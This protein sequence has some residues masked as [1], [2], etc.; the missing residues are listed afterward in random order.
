MQLIVNDVQ[1]GGLG[2]MMTLPPDMYSASDSANRFYTKQIRARSS[3][4]RSM[5]SM[6]FKTGCIGREPALQLMSQA[7]A[8]LATNTFPTQRLLPATTPRP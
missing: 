5:I 1:Y 7:A 3:S 6:D 4:G 2:S 8:C